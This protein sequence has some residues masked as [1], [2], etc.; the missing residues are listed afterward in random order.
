MNRA[1]PWVVILCALFAFVLQAPASAAHA[2]IYLPIHQ[3]T[4]VLQMAEAGEHHAILKNGPTATDRSVP[5]PADKP[6]VVQT[7]LSFSWCLLEAPD[8]IVQVQTRRS[9]LGFWACAPP[10]QRP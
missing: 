6:G 4:A 1:G 3:T 8:H 5:Q 2:R 10:D 9:E 7:R